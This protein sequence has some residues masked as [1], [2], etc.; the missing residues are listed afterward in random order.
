MTDT[1]S[2]LAGGILPALPED[3]R[4]ALAGETN[5]DYF[6][7]LSLFVDQAYRQETCYPERENIFAAFKLTPLNSV[8]AVILGQDPYHEPGQAQGLAFYVPPE[9]KAPPSLRNIAKELGHAPDLM[10]WARSG[11][12]LLNT[13]LTVAAHRPLSHRA[14][15]WERFTDA[16]ID[17]LSRTKAHLVFILWGAHA[18]AKASLIDTS[19]HCTVVSAHPSPLSARR[20]FFGSQPFAR[21]NEYFTR[22]G[23]DPIAW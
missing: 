3:W 17:M 4:E 2:N 6:R 18:A 9:V 1:N 20:G 19:R 5:R 11:V 16:V 23:I 8:K 22:H 7:R 14:F 10:Q 13:T 12:L 21:A 15:G